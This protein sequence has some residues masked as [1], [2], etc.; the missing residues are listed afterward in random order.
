MKFRPPLARGRL[1]RR[2]KRFLADVDT[3][4][5]PLTVHCPNTGAM[6]GCSTPGL[7]VWYSTS[8]SRAR[9]Y[10]HT[11]EVVCAPDGRVGVNTARANG[12]VA[13]A[14]HRDRIPELSGYSGMRRE[15]R[16]PEEDG[17]G[18][19]ARFDFL[20]EGGTVPCWLEVKSL[21]LCCGR[22]RGA[23]PDAVSQRAVRHVEALAARRALGERAVLLFCVQH[24]GVRFATP[25]DE[26]HP[27]Y[28]DALRAAAGAGVE[29]LAYRCRIGPALMEVTSAVPVKL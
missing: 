24:T 8:S 9:K 22:G 10:P 4:K 15:A 16:L 20:L 27:A 14:L 18:H 26:V 13:E 1:I 28:G 2:Y 23:F 7:E 17:E 6:S 5:G 21:T 25:A 3:A 19:R 11:L 29:V 12:L